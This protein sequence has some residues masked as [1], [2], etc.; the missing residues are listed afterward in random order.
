MNNNN[1][2]EIDKKKELL[3]KLKKKIENI[4]INSE[5]TSSFHKNDEIES[6]QNNS[7]LN[8]SETSIRDSQLKHLSNRQ[9]IKKNQKKKKK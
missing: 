8:N 1:Y 4:S 9:T 7:E 3:L 5:E 6:S 2:R